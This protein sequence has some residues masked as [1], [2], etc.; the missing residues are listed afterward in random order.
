VSKEGSVADAGG[1][2]GMR[3]WFTECGSRGLRAASRC[4]QRITF[5]S[6]TAR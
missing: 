3:V 6:G 1:K 5:R 4:E 2:Y